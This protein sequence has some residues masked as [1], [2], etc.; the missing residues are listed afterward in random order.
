MAA[1][2]ARP[3]AIVETRGLLRQALDREERLLGIESKRRPTATRPLAF[4]VAL[5]DLMGYNLRRAH[6]VQ[7]QRFAAVFGPHGIRPVTLSVLGTI[8]ETGGIKQSELG[9]QL[10]IKRANMV[11]VMTELEER[12][13]I[14]R[15][16]SDSDRRAHVVTLTP[17]GR[18]FTMKLL[19][20]HHR[21]EEDLARELGPRERD[22]LL[23]L[24]KKFRKLANEPDLPDLDE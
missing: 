15:R 13:L 17:A 14:A 1:R 10:N 18:K 7:K 12:G 16:L 24:L 5:D 8:Y 6:G 20:L 11:P 21:L 4:G 19:D 2:L 22:Q 9:R 23:M 3:G